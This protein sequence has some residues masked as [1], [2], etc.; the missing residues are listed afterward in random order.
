MP[1]LKRQSTIFSRHP[2]FGCSVVFDMN[3]ALTLRKCSG[4]SSSGIEAIADAISYASLDPATMS[5]AGPTM[6]LNAL[7]DRSIAPLIH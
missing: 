6:T 3:A 5:P 1:R 2:F 7:P 4:H